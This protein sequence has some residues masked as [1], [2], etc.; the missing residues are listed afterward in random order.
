M[1]VDLPALERPT[2][3]ISG[4]VSGGRWC[5]C[6]AVVRN[7]AVCIQPEAMIAW[8]LAGGNLGKGA[9]SAAGGEV[10]IMESSEDKVQVLATGLVALSAVSALVVFKGFS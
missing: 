9:P 3:A 10:G 7:L 4:T 6:G 5:S 8:L 1:Q 2:K